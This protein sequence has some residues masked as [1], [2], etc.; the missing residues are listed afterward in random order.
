MKEVQTD[1]QLIAA[2]GLYCAACNKFLDDK[3]PGCHKNYKASW[4]KIRKCA[5]SKGYNS[6]A[7]CNMDVAHCKTYSNL[8]GKIFSI[9]FKSDR[10]ACISFIRNN[11]EEAF[12][13]YMATHRYKTMKRH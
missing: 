11:G 6:C 12:A 4:C 7:E 1:T 8:I 10:A 5:F 3:C 2:C 13:S 9:L